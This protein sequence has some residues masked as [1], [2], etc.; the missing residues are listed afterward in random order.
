MS[1]SEQLQSKQTTEAAAALPGERER[2]HSI[3]GAQHGELSWA[4]LVALMLG[5]YAE[6]AHPY[7]HQAARLLGL[8]ER[9]SRV[10]LNDL[11]GDLR[12]HQSADGRYRA[13]TRS[14][15]VYADMP[16]SPIAK[17]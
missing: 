1:D 5:T 12:L 10:V 17:D 6:M 9:M 4:Q 8:R 7:L 15:G 14:S 16:S 11:V 3:R 13:A 2:R